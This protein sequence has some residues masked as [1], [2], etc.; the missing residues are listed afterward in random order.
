MSGCFYN[1]GHDKI[2]EDQLNTYYDWDD[3]EEEN[4]NEEELED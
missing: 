2:R 1:F 4:E 3:E